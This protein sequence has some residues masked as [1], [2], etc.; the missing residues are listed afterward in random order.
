VTHNTKEEELLAKLALELKEKK[1]KDKADIEQKIADDKDLAKQQLADAKQQLA[2]EGTE[3]K[4]II[5]RRELKQNRAG[6]PVNVS[7]Y[8]NRKFGGE[9]I[10][11]LKDGHNGTCGPDNGPQC[12]DCF[13]IFPAQSLTQC[14]W[15]I[16]GGCFGKKVYKH[17]HSKETTK[18]PVT[19]S[20]KMVQAALHAAKAAAAAAVKRA[21]EAPAREAANKIYTRPYLL[22]MKN[23]DKEQGKED[24][25]GGWY[26][27]GFDDGGKQHGLFRIDHDHGRYI[28]GEYNHDSPCGHWIYYGKDGS[29]IYA[30][31]H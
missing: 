14:G 5:M 24:E 7:S 31:D 13:A 25:Y 20:F 8:C 16:E 30:R 23:E 15:Y 6:V 27:G 18:F 28:I 12:C 26:R 10:G 29:I 11:L 19:P 22:A 17:D 4:I 21:A 9:V 3:K 1:A 2:D